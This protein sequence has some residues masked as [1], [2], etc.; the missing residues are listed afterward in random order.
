MTQEK[1]VRIVSSTSKPNLFSR[2]LSKIEEDAE[3]KEVRRH[4]TKTSGSKNASDSEEPDSDLLRKYT[5]PSTPDYYRLGSLASNARDDEDEYDAPLADFTRRISSAAMVLA[6]RGKYEPDSDDSGSTEEIPRNEVAP[7]TAAAA[8]QTEVA[9]NILEMMQRM[10]QDHEETKKATEELLLANKLE[11]QR[12]A[13]LIATQPP[14]APPPVD[15]RREVEIWN[16]IAYENQKYGALQAFST[17]TQLLC[18]NN[19][20]AAARIMQPL[21]N[22]PQGDILQLM[23]EK[24][25]IQPQDRPDRFFST[26]SLMADKLRSVPG[27]FMSMDDMYDIL[28]GHDA[29]CRRAFKLSRIANALGATKAREAAPSQYPLLNRIRAEQQEREQ[30]KQPPT[31]TVFLKA[32]VANTPNSGQQIIIQQD[33]CDRKASWAMMDADDMEYD[34][35]RKASSF[36]SSR[37]SSNSS[38]NFT[39]PSGASIQFGQ[40][41]VAPQQSTQASAKICPFFLKNN[42]KFSAEQCKMSHDTGATAA[43]QPAPSNVKICPFFLKNNCKFSADQCKMSHDQPGA[44]ANTGPLSEKA[45]KLNND[46]KLLQS[47]LSEFIEMPLIVMGY[48][49]NMNKLINTINEAEAVLRH[50]LTFATAE[51]VSQSIIRDPV[52]QGLDKIMNSWWHRI[53]PSEPKPQ[54]LYDAITKLGALINDAN[55]KIGYMPPLPHN[56]NNNFSQVNHFQGG[57]KDPQ[58]ILAQELHR[59]ENKNNNVSKNNK[60]DKNKKKGKGG[61][62]N[63]NSSGGNSGNNNGNN[64]NNNNNGNGNKN[65][66]GG[67][68]GSNGN[69]G[70][71]RGGKGGGGHGGKHRRNN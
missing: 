1:K 38:N 53:A 67:H 50:T 30:R 39:L 8:A 5:G 31:Q 21:V 11:A 33:Y 59:N 46:L 20:E 56:N 68:G 65:H 47:I 37:S 15:S 3:P 45:E 62:K 54:S 17:Y 64:R 43:T 34:K 58:Q 4:P 44:P 48:D 32:L 70:S 9:S 26:R 51:D 22:A 25:A 55:R 71:N 52:V 27:V 63:N 41:A 60:N 24:Q 57:K 12:L 29:K 35:A 2:R 13:T 40:H 49:N 16:R 42:C 6:N 69:N 10:V 36:G 23:A 7:A 66:G 28:K 19:T 14:S 61:N 18:G